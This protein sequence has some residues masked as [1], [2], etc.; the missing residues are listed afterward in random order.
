[1]PSQDKVHA[2]L[3]QYVILCN[4]YL[5]VIL[6][7]KMTDINSPTRFLLHTIDEFLSRN[8]GEFV[9]AFE[10]MK[11]IYMR[12]FMRKFKKLFITLDKSKQFIPF[13]S[14]TRHFHF[15]H[16][17]ITTVTPLHRLHHLFFATTPAITLFRVVYKLQ[18]GVHNAT[19]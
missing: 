7:L 17:L 3:F 2:L 1:M 8:S 4:M 15:H 16:S 9:K 19:R 6:H 5:C 10:I 11:I 13:Y 18:Q 12:I 14:V